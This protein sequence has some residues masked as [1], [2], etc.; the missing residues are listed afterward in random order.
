MALIKEYAYTK[1][2]FI[3]PEK[4][5]LEAGKIMSEKNIGSVIIIGKDSKPAGIFTERDFLHAVS[6]NRSDAELGSYVGKVI[7]INEMAAISKAV[8]KMVENGIRRLLV[9]DGSGDAQGIITA[10]DILNAVYDDLIE[11]LN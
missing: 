6:D 2:V 8:E 11:I 9:V 5:V 10:R 7:T 4:T 1:P 3:N